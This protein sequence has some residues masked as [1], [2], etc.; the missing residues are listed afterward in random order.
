MIDKK[1]WI[2]YKDDADRKIIHEMLD[3]VESVMKNYAPRYTDFYNPYQVS[4]C[5]P[6]LNHIS[7]INYV[8][9]GGNERSERQILIFYPEWMP[10]H[11]IDIPIA[12]LKIQGKF[13]K[14]EVTHRDFL[15]AVLGLGLR[16]EKIGDIMVEDGQ[17]NLIA[18]KEVCEY[19]RLNLNKVSRYK[20]DSEYI[21]FDALIQNDEK[22]CKLIYTTVASLR[23]DAIAGAGFGTSRS[24]ITPLIKKGKMKVNWKPVCNPSYKTAKGDLISSQGIGRM[25]LHEV[26]GETRK[27][28]IRVVIKRLV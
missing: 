15:G 18:F 10:L 23:L 2:A 27:G 6:I 5:I 1:Q 24:A 25:I 8:I 28:R 22:D 17:A 14:K 20:V 7:E 16:R 9:Q 21:P 13:R 26:D 12:A 4:L 19:I 3:K 11:E